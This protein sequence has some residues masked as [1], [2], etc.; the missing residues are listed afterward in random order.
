[1][2]GAATGR[3]DPELHRRREAVRWFLDAWARAKALTEKAFGPALPPPIFADDQP[4]HQG[5]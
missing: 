3:Q 5:S 1:M 2:R 4:A